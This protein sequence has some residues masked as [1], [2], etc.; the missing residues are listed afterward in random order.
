M[1]VTQFVS[2]KFSGIIGVVLL[3]S[4]YNSVT[5]GHEVANIIMSFYN[6][7]KSSGNMKK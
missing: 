3:Q 5:N 7:I 2:P 4:E 6:L 1:D